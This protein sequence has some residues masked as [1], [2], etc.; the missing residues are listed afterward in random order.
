MRRKTIAE[1]RLHGTY[2]P[3]REK[4]RVQFAT[5]DGVEIKAPAFVRANKLANAE[6]KSLI[7]HL[8]SQGILRQTDVSLLASY[9]LLYARYRESASAVQQQGLTITIT[10][11]TRTGKTEKPIPNPNCRLEVI[12]QSAMMKAMAKLGLSPVDRSRI[13]APEEADVVDETGRD[14]FD[15][16][17]DNDEDDADLAYLELPRRIK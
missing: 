7:T 13:E 8:L 15:R 16:F 6:W 10:S 9:C 5:P 4:K 12:Y 17:L 14:A 1:K 3:Y 11:T 2:Q